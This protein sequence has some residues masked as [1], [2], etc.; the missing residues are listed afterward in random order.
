MQLEEMSKEEL[1]EQ[2]EQLEIKIGSRASKTDI[3]KAINTAL[4]GDEEAEA[5]TDESKSKYVEINFANDPNDK[6]P[7]FFGLKGHSYR[8]PRGKWVKCPRILLPTIRLAMKRVQDEDG[9]WMEVEAYPYQ[10]KGE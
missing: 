4:N 3:I 1:I 8:F 5:E 9:T 10:I 6:T 2:A 7:V